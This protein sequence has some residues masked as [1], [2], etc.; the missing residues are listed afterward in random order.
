MTLIKR[1]IKAG[2]F[3]RTGICDYYPQKIENIQEILERVREGNREARDTLILGHLRLATSIVNRYLS[4]LNSNHSVMAD[5]LD[6]A[7]IEGIVDAVDRIEKGKMQHDN[8]TGYIVYS[9]HNSIN[10]C[11]KKSIPIHVPRNHKI[12]CFLSLDE[13][14]HVKEGWHE[15]H[16][17]VEVKDEL[18][19]LIQNEIERKLIDLKIMGHSDTEVAAILGLNRTKLIRMKQSLRERYIQRERKNARRMV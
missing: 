1:K 7:A 13:N 8:V 9:I 16:D 11:L 5:D 2:S 14:H 15:F 12:P 19:N 17:L 4:Y 3:Q 18:D 10:R 6:G